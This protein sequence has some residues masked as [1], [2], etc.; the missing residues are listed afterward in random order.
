MP[1]SQNIRSS[2]LERVLLTDVGIKTEDLLTS[3]EE[4]ELLALSALLSICL[5]II[6]GFRNNLGL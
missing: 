6:V 1:T 5:A 2:F 4:K 3:I